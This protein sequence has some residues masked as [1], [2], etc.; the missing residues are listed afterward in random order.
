MMIRLLS[1]ALLLFSAGV[2]AQP[3]NLPAQPMM[4][5]VELSDADFRGY[6]KV[7]DGLKALDL[8]GVMA[9]GDDQMAML[10]G[11]AA[12]DKFQSLL[13]RSGFSV[14]EFGPKA[15]SIAMAMGGAEMQDQN[16]QLAEARQQLEQM[17]G[18]MSAAQFKML[19][20][21]MQMA[22]GMVEQMQDQ[23][24]QNLELAQ[25]YRAQ[26]EAA[27]QALEQAQSR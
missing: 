7:I 5:I 21:Q 4:Q 1:I 13:A 9:S 11:L 3:G 26:L 12:S 18:Q 15:Y 14:D 27:H 16:P 25:R 20:E 19:Q 10:Q 6:L 24:P 23:P 8:S 17:R 2:Q 22:M